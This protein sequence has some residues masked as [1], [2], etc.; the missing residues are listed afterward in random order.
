VIG[1]WKIQ[2][3]GKQK[4][5]INSSITLRKKKMSKCSNCRHD[6]HCDGDLHADEYGICTC[7]NCECKSKA[8]DKSYE[9]EIEY[10]G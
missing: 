8:E 7:E 4:I 2:V 5:Q 3:N 6:C 1:M 10:D 9:D